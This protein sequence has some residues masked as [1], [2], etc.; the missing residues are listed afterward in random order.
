MWFGG[1]VVAMPKGGSQMLVICD[2][3]VG[4]INFS[5]ASTKSTNPESLHMASEGCDIFSFSFSAAI[6]KIPWCL[7]DMVL[8]SNVLGVPYRDGK[9]MFT[10]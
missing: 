3:I 9:L 8:S 10:V 4:H 2:D 5:V 1:K 6:T 7:Q